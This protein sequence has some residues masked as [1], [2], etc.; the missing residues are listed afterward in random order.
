MNEIS[1]MDAEVVIE[2]VYEEIDYKNIEGIILASK[3][4]RRREILDMVGIKFEVISEEIDEKKIEFDIVNQM[5]SDDMYMVA[6]RLTEVLS[7]E[8]SKIVSIKN[9]NKLVIGSD[10]V[11]V[12]K[13]GILGKPRD[14]KEARHML[15]SLCGRTHRVYTGVCISLNGRVIDRFS[16][17][18]EVSFFKLSEEIESIIDD[19][20]HSKSPMDKAGGY[21]IQDKGAL[22]IEK[23]S[24][25][26]Y[27]V[28]GLPINKLYQKLNRIIN[29]Q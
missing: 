14:E 29:M 15:K 13:E 19:Y 23:I 27:T 4:P 7:E 9:K 17:S 3:S 28:M 11:V 16:T 21:G 6:E 24:G 12:H 2:A 1:I 10:T 5:K 25:D 8:K 26:Y 20:I 18:T 22:L